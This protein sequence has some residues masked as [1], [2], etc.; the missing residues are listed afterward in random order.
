MI[1][2]VDCPA[3]S[4]PPDG[5]I[6]ASSEFDAVQLRVPPPVFVSSSEHTQELNPLEEQCSPV[7]KLP[8]MTDSIGGVRVG[9]GVGG[10]IRVGVGDGV[11]GFRGRMHCP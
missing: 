2:I 8:G 1:N 10:G 4:V 3:D 6:S 9:V 11:G 7:L 5:F